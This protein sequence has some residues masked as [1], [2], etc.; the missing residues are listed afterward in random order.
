MITHPTAI[1]QRPDGRLVFVYAQGLKNFELHPGRQYHVVSVNESTTLNTG[2]AQTIDLDVRAH[3]NWEI[4]LDES[5]IVT[6]PPLILDG[7]VWFASFA[8]NDNVCDFG[9][10]RVWS[11]DYIGDPSVDGP[12]GAAPYQVDAA[13][14]RLVPTT[15]ANPDYDPEDEESPEFL[16]YY[17]ALQLN[18]DPLD[19]DD[20]DMSVIFDLSLR[21]DVNCATVT[22]HDREGNEVVTYAGNPL[23]FSLQARGS[24]YTDLNPEVDDGWTTGATVTDIDLNNFLGAFTP[25]GV[26]TDLGVEWDY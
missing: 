5:E 14:E 11:V 12:D 16:A 26:P 24:R 17:N 1:A 7:K 20:L 3:V 6:T 13:S 15:F 21:P 23:T 4:L 10:A 18:A 2:A 9:Y 22:G 19:D 25:V 8:A